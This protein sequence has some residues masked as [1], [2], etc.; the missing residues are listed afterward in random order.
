MEKTITDL[1]ADYFKA[2]ENMD[3]LIKKATANIK[4]ATENNETDKIYLLKQKR[5]IF[6]TQK[7]ELLETAHKLKNYYIKEENLLESA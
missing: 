7:R 6:Y 1:S 2:A 4:E 3:E 5:L